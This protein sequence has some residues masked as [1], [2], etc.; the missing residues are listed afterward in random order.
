M[1][2]KTDPSQRP[3]AEQVLSVPALQPRVKATFQK[4][5]SHKQHRHRWRAAS[6]ECAFQSVSNEEKVGRVSLCVRVF[7]CLCV[8]A[9]VN[10]CVW[11]M[12]GHVT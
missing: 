4:C 10:V 11:A 3:T 7:V 8:H 12:G 2:L 1:L 9:R 5:V 6:K